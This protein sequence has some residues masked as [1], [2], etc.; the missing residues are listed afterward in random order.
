MRVERRECPPI[1]RGKTEVFTAFAGVTT[2]VPTVRT[3][4]PHE[5]GRGACRGWGGKNR[6]RATDWGRSHARRT[7]FV[8][9]LKIFSSANCL[10]LSDSRKRHGGQFLFSGIGG[11]PGAAPVDGFEDG[12][13][14][15]SPTIHFPMRGLS[16]AQ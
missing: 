11:R 1:G 4:G 14:A 8:S 2:T 16:H 10:P 5:F 15:K 6:V 3:N 12:S 13:G 7:F 9:A